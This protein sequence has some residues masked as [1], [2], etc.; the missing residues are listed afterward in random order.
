MFPT[1]TRT[2][3]WIAVRQGDYKL[4]ESPEL[5][6]KELYDVR[7]DPREKADLSQANAGVVQGLEVKLSSWQEE[8]RRIAGTYQ[9]GGTAKLTPA[10][11]ERLRALGYLR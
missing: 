3:N 5:G 2:R 10:E 11:T 9:K 4:V 6:R 7:K 1:T 8:E